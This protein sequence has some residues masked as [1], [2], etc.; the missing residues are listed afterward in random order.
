MNPAKRIE[1]VPDPNKFDL[2]TDRWDSQGNRILKN[3]Y[4]SFIVE[5]RQVFERPVNSGNLWDEANKPA[6]RVECVFND[7]GHISSK[8]FVFD[9]AHK[10][11]VAPLTGDAKAH[12]ELEQMRERNQA[13]EAE[14]ASIRKERETIQAAV[15]KSEPKIEMV[16]AAAPEEMAPAAKQA[17]P[18]LNKRST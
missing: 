5:G 7:L 4:R 18:T 8:R 12:Y 13:L 2:V 17:M 6:G 16:E 14:L 11:Y 15:K 10:E 3:K 1:Y 9:A